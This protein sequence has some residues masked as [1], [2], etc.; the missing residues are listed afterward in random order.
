MPVKIDILNLPEL[1]KQ[2]SLEINRGRL[3][4]VVFDMDLARMYWL[5]SFGH[6]SLMKVC[7]V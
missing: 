3:P 6:H 2:Q 7:S 5:L 4:D 1:A